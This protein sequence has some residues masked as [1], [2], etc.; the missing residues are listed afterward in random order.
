MRLTNRRGKLEVLFT[1]MFE[2]LSAGTMIVALLMMM[3][4]IGI[5]FALGRLSARR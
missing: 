2:S 4:G 1:T 3:V 5:G